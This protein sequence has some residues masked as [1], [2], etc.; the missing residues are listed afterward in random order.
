MPS[1][2]QKMNVSEVLS[3]IHATNQLEIE[4]GELAQKK[5][6]SEEVRAYG[7]RL[8]RDH[9]VADGKILDLATK[10]NVAILEPTPM[11]AEEKSNM[12]VHRELAPKL[13]ALSGT[14]FDNQFLSAIQMGHADAIKML[15]GVNTEDAKVQGL[16]AKL[17]PIL[18]QHLTVA[19]HLNQ[20]LAS[21]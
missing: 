1:G 11:S 4:V 3:R 8:V 5:G 12:A 9:A 21:K 15:E 14:E 17:I 18:K 13:Q 10:E 16:I 7:D 19:E 6:Q 20:K 2:S